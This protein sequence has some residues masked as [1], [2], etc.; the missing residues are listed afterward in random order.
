MRNLKKK[1]D[2]NKTPQKK[3]ALREHAETLRQFKETKPTNDKRK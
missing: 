3:P 2:N 1:K